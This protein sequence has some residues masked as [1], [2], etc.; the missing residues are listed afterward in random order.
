MNINIAAVGLGCPFEI[1][2]D[3][4]PALLDTT[5]LTLKERGVACESVG[6]VMHDLETVKAAASVLK[7]SDADVLMICIATWSEDHHLLDLLSYVDKPVILRAY[8]AFDTGSL[9]CAHQIG[10]VF[11]DIGKSYEFIYGDPDDPKCADEAKKIATAYALAGCMS[12][13]RMGAIGGR[14][15]GM[16]EIAY[17]EFSIKEK[18][19]ARIVNIDEKEMTGK[20]AAMTDDEAKAL[21]SEKASML[22]PCKQLSSDEAMLESMKYY[23]ALRSLVDEYELEALAVKCYTTFMGKVCLGYSILAEEGIMGACEGDVTNALT[24][25]M[26]YELSGKPVNNT[27]LLY[28]H[29]DKNAILFAH[30]G[31]SG[32]SIAGGEIEL[33]PVRLA[34][35]GVC[36]RFVAMPGKVTAVNICGHG[37]K[38]RMAVM[39]G[40]AIPCGM[41]FPGN[42]VVIKFDKPT[43][44]INKDIM[45]YGI[46]HHW[47]V[48]YGDF[49]DELERF[50]KIK[51]MKFYKIS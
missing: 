27:D 11:T 16:T 31:S 41:E 33:A 51:N 36:S 42:P 20:V 1:G 37:E 40:D 10:A 17:D 32:F 23:G 26:L 13:V 46:G 34:E 44:Q 9:C 28:I 19:G 38:F 8:P 48:G 35:C 14:V 18:L 30:C 47:M 7:T 29:E 15:K 12:K 25:K 2:F 3:E 22:A 49:A 24:M 43:D 21:L 50:C 6:V 4:A 5:V 45:K 39:V